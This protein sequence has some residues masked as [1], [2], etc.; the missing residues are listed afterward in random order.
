[1][2]RISRLLLVLLVFGVMF[3]G[4][5][6]SGIID[7]NKPVISYETLTEDQVKKGAV[8]GGEIKTN[9]GAVA[10]EYSTENGVKKGGSSYYYAIL[11]GNKVM[12]FKT[13]SSSNKS[14]LDSQARQATDLL[15]EVLSGMGTQPSDDANDNS[16]KSS[17]KKKSKNNKKKDAAQKEAEEEAALQEQ[18]A[19]QMAVPFKGKVSKLD[20]DVE[21][22]LRESLTLQGE[23]EPILEIIPYAV[24]ATMM[25]MNTAIGFLAVGIVCLLLTVLLFIKLRR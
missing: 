14:M 3:T 4:F 13:S 25:S 17:K 6:V 24:S 10:E 12:A 2:R 11:V 8:I 15:D 20:E 9:L 21:R 7:N 18:T 23:S 16:A 19:E 1:M 22:Y 5:G